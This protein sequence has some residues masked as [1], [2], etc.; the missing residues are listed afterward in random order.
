[1]LSFARLE[2][3]MMRAAL[4]LAFL[5]SSIWFAGFAAEAQTAA[6]A[7]ESLHTELLKGRC[8]FISIDEETDEEQVKRCPGRGGA[9]VLTRASH[10]N[11]YL[12]FRWSRS[13]VAE[14][15]VKGW[16]LGDKV[17]WRGVRSAQGFAP[18]AAIVRVI[19]KHPETMRGGG[20]VLAV[21]RIER[22]NACLAA[23]VDVGANKGAN[24][25]A[26]A[27]ADAYARTFVCR[28]GK[29]RLFGP[30][31]AWTEQVIGTQGSERK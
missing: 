13:R 17:E 14:D 21:L 30:A 28:N 9:Q 23:A 25:L 31:T 18:Y 27:A 29:P 24:G 11:V 4:C 12:S 26:R 15:V 10:T 5:C 8:K 7:P 1:M 2:T 3:I 16:S 20:H 19:T 22:R 6:P